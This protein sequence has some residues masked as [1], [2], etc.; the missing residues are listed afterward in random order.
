MTVCSSG[1]GL[2]FHEGLKSSELLGSIV[3]F[4]KKKK[5]FFYQC[6][7]FNLEQGHRLE[8][9]TVLVQKFLREYIQ[10]CESIMHP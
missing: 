1:T 10:K 6:Q 8:K 2:L 4:E 5:C 3:H 7:R 9:S